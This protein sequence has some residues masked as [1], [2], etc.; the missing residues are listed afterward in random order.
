MALVIISA[1]IALVVILGAPLLVVRLL[2]GRRL[3]KT[4]DSGAS[5]APDEAAP[6]ECEPD[7]RA[8][9]PVV[10]R[11]RTGIDFPP[12]AVERCV[13]QPRPFTRDDVGEATLRFEEIPLETYAR[14][15]DSGD[16]ETELFEGEVC[17]VCRHRDISGFWN[18]R[19]YAERPAGVV[20]Y[21]R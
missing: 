12:F 20:W 11:E 4:G 3:R 21:G 15:R 8:V 5:E 17:Y 14:I 2:G 6:A 7:A 10:I 19:V 9:D 18:M 13:S 1:F 16:W